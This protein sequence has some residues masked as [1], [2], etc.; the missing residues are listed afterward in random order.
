MILNLISGPRNISTAMMYSFAQRNDSIVVDEPFYAF[1]L[2]N[3]NVQHPGGEEVIQHMEGEPDKIIKHLN[4]LIIAPKKEIV[5]IKNMAHHIDQMPLEFLKDW[6]NLFLI[7][8]PYR[9]LASYSQVIEQPNMQDIGIQRQFE[10]WNFLKNEGQQPV[11]IDSEDLLKNPSKFLKMLCDHL[12]IQFLH[13]MLKWNK[14]PRKEDGIWAKY[15]YKNVHSSTGF[16]KTISKRILPEHLNPLY[17]EANEYYQ[18]LKE[19]SLSL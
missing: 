5:F 8:D 13:S 12:E 4:T 2:I 1:Y 7:R 16:K 11:I 19:I 18:K 3:N 6:K 15:W 14:G 10:L 9:V 17:Q